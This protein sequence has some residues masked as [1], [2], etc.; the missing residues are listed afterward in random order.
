MNEP[1]I[2]KLIDAERL[3]EIIGYEVQMV[4]KMAREK[5]IPAYKRSR[6]N[7]G[8]RFRLSEV[9]EALRSGGASSSSCS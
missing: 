1:E 8:W 6:R 7:A 2:E 3:G 5:E 9:L 4:N